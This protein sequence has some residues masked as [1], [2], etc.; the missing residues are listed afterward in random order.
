MNRE[1]IYA[2]IFALAPAGF[3]TTGRKLV[4][5]DDVKANEMPALFQQQHDETVK[6]NGNLPTTIT[7]G[8]TWWV[9]VH[10]DES[11]NLVPSQILNPLL[12]EIQAAFA[13]K[14][15]P[16]PAGAQTLGGLVSQCYIDG[17]IETDEGYLGELSIARIPIHFVIG[18]PRQ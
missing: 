3:V 5:W 12:D 8:V 15:G 6:G 14:P 1:A 2:A 7:G 4:L 17:T 18:E 13:P 9:Y 11:Q 16:W 10:E